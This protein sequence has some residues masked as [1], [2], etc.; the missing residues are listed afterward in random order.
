MLGLQPPSKFPRDVLIHLPKM[1]GRVEPAEVGR[2]A[3]QDG[4]DPIQRL[5]QRYSV[6]TANGRFHL[7]PYS[8]HRPPRRPAVAEPPAGIAPRLLFP[9]V[10]PQ[11]VEAIPC[12]D[13][14]SLVFIDSHPQP[15]QELP[16]LRHV[17]FRGLPSAQ[18][19]EASRPGESH[20]E[21]LSE[22]CLN[23][24]AHTAPATEPCRT[25]SCQCAH[26]F[27]SRRAMRATQ[28]VALRR[29]PRSFLYF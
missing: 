7:V 6:L 10:H 24:S 8:L 4:I 13:H 2:P 27:G 29:W 16:Q 28:C 1:L 15:R 11:K 26:S 20:P 18:H 25:P 9:K 21:P 3:T 5:L 23:L 22:P 14:T 19:H 17:N 12:I